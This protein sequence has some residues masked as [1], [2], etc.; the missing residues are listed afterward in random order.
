MPGLLLVLLI[1]VLELNIV[2]HLVL[3]ELMLVSKGLLQHIDPVL[4]LIEVAINIRVL[5]LVVIESILQH[6]VL[7][8]HL[9]DIRFHL[10]DLP[11]NFGKPRFIVPDGFSEFFYLMENLIFLGSQPVVLVEK[12]LVVAVQRNTFF[13]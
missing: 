10:Q 8:R 6:P 3:D 1:L 13:F 11:S 5:I 9:I 12:F 7:L 4:L 2:L